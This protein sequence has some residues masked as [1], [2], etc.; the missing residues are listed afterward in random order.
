MPPSPPAQVPELQD[1]KGKRPGSPPAKV[2]D[3][4]DTM[5]ELPPLPP[6]KDIHLHP[7]TKQPVFSLSTDRAPPTQQPVYETAK[8]SS[9]S[10]FLFPGRKFKTSIRMLVDKCSKL[11]SHSERRLWWMNPTRIMRPQC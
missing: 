7:L 1:T 3:L 6:V 8:D 2:K 11:L 4:Q 9:S 5:V 10:G